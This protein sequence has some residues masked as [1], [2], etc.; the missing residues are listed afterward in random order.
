VRSY[1]WDAANRLVKIVYADNGSTTF[2]YDAMSQ[3]RLITEKAADGS[4][5]STT[6]LLWLAG[7]VWQEQDTSARVTRRYHFN[8]AQTL[9]YTGANTT[10]TSTTSTLTLSDHLG[11]HRE[12]V[13]LVSGTP[14]LTG[15]RDYDPYGK[16]TQ[17][18]VVPSNA[19]YTGHWLHERSGLELALYR[20]Y[21]PEFGRWLN[22]DPIGERG[23]LN[24]YGYMGN[25]P[26]MG[27]DLLG[28]LV[29]GTFSMSTG[30][31]TLTDRDTG[32]CVSAKAFSGNEHANDPAYANAAGKDT[33][34]LPAGSYDIL[35]HPSGLVH[36]DP[37]YDLDSAPQ[38]KVRDDYDPK[39][40]RGKFR[41][42]K[43]NASNG[44]V[45]VTDDGGK[46]TDQWDKIHALLQ[47]TK[48]TTVK[49]APQG[50]TRTYYGNMTVTP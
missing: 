29:D 47:K 3:R 28:L 50:R 16:A 20:A 33:G 48:T 46:N 14:T 49:D 35:N 1:E 12:V 21:D 5:T 39:S 37:W 10:P 18:G 44:C 43:G 34:P 36:G 32:E 42:H 26:L 7:R 19:A 2:Q 40:K 24:L 38:D 13:T 15:R 17:V 30:I 41:L 31:V 8:G 45:T 11:S 6:L 23:G 9:T 22:E 25:G 27:V 4:V